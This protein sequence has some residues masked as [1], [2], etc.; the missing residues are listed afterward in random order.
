MLLDVA[1]LLYAADALVTCWLWTPCVLLQ[2]P[3]EVTCCLCGEPGHTG[4][5]NDCPEPLPK[6]LAG[7]IHG[8]RSRETRDR[9]M[10]QPVELSPGGRGRGRGGGPGGGSRWPG[11]QYADAHRGQYREAPQQQAARPQGRGGAPPGQGYGPN[12]RYGYRE[13]PD[14]RGR[15]AGGVHPVRRPEPSFDAPGAPGGAYVPEHAALRHA[16][17]AAPPVDGLAAQALEQARMHAAV[18]H[19][20][21]DQLGMHAPFAAAQPPEGRFA[22]PAQAWVPQWHGALQPHPAAALQPTDARAAP[23]GV[24]AR[25][26]YPPPRYAH[27]SEQASLPGGPGQSG[28]RWSG[29]CVG[30]AGRTSHD[31]KHAEHRQNQLYDRSWEHNGRYQPRGRR[32]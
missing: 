3:M 7:E 26:A 23:Y 24:Q 14:S 16:G 29:G 8:E 2:E 19:P 28:G 17:H 22:P 11:A 25:P 1:T 12:N 27:F 4:Q 5:L 20:P 6:V 18:L 9:R 31:V 32:R 13:G 30:H 10:P 15:A 21:P